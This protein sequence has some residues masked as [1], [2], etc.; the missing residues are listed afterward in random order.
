VDRPGRDA[1]FCVSPPAARERDADLPAAAV[2]APELRLGA[3]PRFALELRSDAEPLARRADAVRS[4]EEPA[5]LGEA[6]VLFDDELARL[7]EEAV[8]FDDEL[9]R[10]GEE[11]VPLDEEPVLFEDEPARLGEEAVLFDDELARLGE[12]PVPLD[13]EPVPPLRAAPACPDRRAALFSDPLLP[14]ARPRLPLRG[15]DEPLADFED[16]RP[17]DRARPLAPRSLST[18]MSTSLFELGIPHD[19]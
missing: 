18:A 13:E 12:E 7:G 2:S 6:L 17:F 4:G 9:A 8:L 1:C 19:A 3:E 14:A 5:L 11:P 16:D 15:V 10:L